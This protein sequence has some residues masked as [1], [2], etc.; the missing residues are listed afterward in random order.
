MLEGVLVEDEKVRQRGEYKVNNETE[1][2]AKCQLIS[3]CVLGF[4]DTSFCPKRSKQNRVEEE[5][6]DKQRSSP[7]DEKQR[8]GLTLPVS[9]LKKGFISPWRWSQSEKLRDGVVNNR[10]RVNILALPSVIGTGPT[11]ERA[12]GQ[13][14][15]I[16][17]IEEE[18]IRDSKNV[19]HCRGCCLLPAGG[20]R[21]RIEQTGK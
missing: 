1:D 7:G 17:G 18:V 14:G 4:Q 3:R 16:D 20:G 13:K 11:C 6:R 5:R 21:R 15:S 9:S 2:P 12:S 10:Q 8:E 19:I